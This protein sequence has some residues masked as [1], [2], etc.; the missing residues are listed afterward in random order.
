[1]LFSDLRVK[2]LL[3]P[4]GAAPRSIERDRL[5]HRKHLE[6]LGI[7]GTRQ[8]NAIANMAYVDWPPGERNTADAPRDY[9]PRIAQTIDPQTLAR[10]SRGTVDLTVFP[11]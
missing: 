8:I 6:A 5:F 2:D 10:Q 7:S 3:D 4:S 11:A 9:L 1:V